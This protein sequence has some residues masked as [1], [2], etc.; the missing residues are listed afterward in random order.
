MRAAERFLLSLCVAF[1]VAVSPAS[2]D[3][4]VVLRI[5]M[6]QSSSSPEMNQIIKPFVSY[7]ES[8]SKGRIKIKV[9]PDGALHGASQGFKALA[10]DVTDIAPAYP[11][12]Q[13][14]SFN[15]NLV[16]MLPLAFPTAYVGGR[17]SQ[18][19]YAQYFAGEWKKM[20]CFPLF[21]PVTATYDILTTKPVSSIKDLK[22]MKLRGG[23]AALNEIIERLG[24]I[25]IT[26]Q[27]PEVYT[28]FQQGVVDGLLFD[29]ASI[30]SFRLDEIGKYY[31]PLGITRVGIPWAMS[32]KNFNRL[33]PDLQQVMLDAGRE[34]AILYADYVTSGTDAA[35]QAMTKRGIK[36]VNLP[37]S[38]HEWV[39]AQVEP[40]WR[41][42]VKKNDGRPAQALVDTLRSKV[43]HYGAMTRTEFVKLAKEAPIVKSPS[44]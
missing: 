34:A 3:E 40:M 26:I 33:P 6:H 9:F 21:S 35:I 38:E 36:T 15:L 5:S 8:Q 16:T 32:N 43:K 11:I 2:A 39:R 42:F 4:P 7:V 13:S 28:A 20:E 10:T 23:G 12:Y 14:H 41:A 29:T 19:L 1:V 44:K 31:M 17:V 27:A 30:L 18:E 24:A 22:G 37:A 25:P